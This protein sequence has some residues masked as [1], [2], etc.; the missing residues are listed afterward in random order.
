MIKNYYIA[1]G[2]SRRTPYGNPRHPKVVQGLSKDTL[3]GTQ[4]RPKHRNRILRDT[5]RRAT[6]HK[7]IYT[8]TKYTRNLNPP[9]YSDRLIIT[10]T[11]VY[12]QCRPNRNCHR[13]RRG[14]WGRPRGLGETP[15][16]QWITA[17]AMGRGAFL[18]GSQGGGGRGINWGGD[19]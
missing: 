4:S 1:I 15:E 8:Y 18:R 19:T 17:V 14:V 7:D 16:P 13:R 6:H 2:K 3:I 11:R 9:P 5:R 10:H 12:K